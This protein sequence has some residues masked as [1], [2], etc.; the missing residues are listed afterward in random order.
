MLASN[1]WDDDDIVYY[2]FGYYPRRDT[3]SRMSI[4][5]TRTEVNYADTML[6]AGKSQDNYLLTTAL[7]A[8]DPY[9]AVSVH[10]LDIAVRDYVI[11]GSRSRDDDNDK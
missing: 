4:L 5:R 2:T 1:C 6:P 9:G 7:Q 3:T 10:T 11:S 8:S